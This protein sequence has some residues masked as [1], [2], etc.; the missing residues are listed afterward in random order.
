MS[1][2][3]LFEQRGRVGVLTLNRPETRNAIDDELAEAIASRCDRLNR[4]M[5]VS[6]LVLTGAGSAFCSGGNVK[7]MQARAGM[8]GGSPAE[9]RRG[10]R[11]GIQRIPL[12]MYD[13]EI[14]V[15]AAVNGPAVGAGCDLALMCDVR[16]AAEQAS[17]AESF[18]RLGLV[19]G[20]GGAW[21]LPRIVGAARAY[22]M[23]LTGDPVD[24]ERAL[25]W[26]LVSAVH[27]PQDLLPQALAIAERMARHPPHSLRLNK[28]LLRETERLTLPQSL[29]LAAALQSIAQ[30]T[31]DFRE[32]VTAMLEKR[33]PDFQG[34]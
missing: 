18:V 8:F 22:E 13:L 25:D 19:S 34:R 17:F 27:P 2:A 23:T 12:A 32:G 5:S 14:P 15:V 26:G 16:V 21:F 1:E 31:D 7:D 20:D 28:R 4:E 11:F 24:A 29:E 33:K 30:A 6:C 3:V 9:A 10:Y